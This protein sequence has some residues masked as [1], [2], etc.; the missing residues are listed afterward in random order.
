MREP[1][2][3]VIG[4]NALRSFII[5]PIPLRSGH[6]GRNS[7]TQALIFVPFGFLTAETA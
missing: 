1:R 2:S 6:T 4:C 5:S 3:V 7:A